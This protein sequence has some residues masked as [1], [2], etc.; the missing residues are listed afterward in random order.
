MF[1]SLFLFFSVYILNILI[2]DS[3]LLKFCSTLSFTWSCVHFICQPNLAE[4]WYF[5]FARWT[6]SSSVLENH[7]IQ[8]KM[9]RTWQVFEHFASELWM[10]KWTPIVVG[11]GAKR[12]E[13][14]FSYDVTFQTQLIFSVR[15]LRRW[16][17]HIKF[18]VLVRDFQRSFCLRCDLCKMRHR[19]TA[20]C[21]LHLDIS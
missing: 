18:D 19:V 14:H 2:D 3:A 6:S 17:H 11:H 7:F 5:G 15:R 13:W 8:F 1:F 20:Q 16:R 10:M 21:S 12:P 4:H 9:N